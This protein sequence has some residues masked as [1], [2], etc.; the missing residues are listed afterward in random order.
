[1]KIIS[2]SELVETIAKKSSLSKKD[3]KAT[4]ESTIE[5]IVNFVKKGNKVSL[6][7]FGSFQPAKRKATIKRNPKTGKE[8]KIPAKTVFKFKVS[9]ALNDKMK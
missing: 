2:K 3:A 7:G 9:K 1:M 6:I 8:I 4:L 5:S